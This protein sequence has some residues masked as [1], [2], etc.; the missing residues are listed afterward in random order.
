MIAYQYSLLIAIDELPGSR[1]QKYAADAIRRINM[2]LRSTGFGANKGFKDDVMCLPGGFS[3]R[4]DN[5][6]QRDMAIDCLK[7]HPA[8]CSLIFMKTRVR[9][10]A[11]GKRKQYFSAKPRL[12]KSLKIQWKALLSQSSVNEIIH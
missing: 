11:S 6:E 8:A 5:K 12:S 1:R 10:S 9:K 4:F 3:W 7:A 2:D